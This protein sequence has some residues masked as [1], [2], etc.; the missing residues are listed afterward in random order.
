MSH[1]YRFQEDLQEDVDE[2]RVI[3][4]TEISSSGSLPAHYRFQE[5]NI[6]QKEN[7]NISQ[8]EN[9]DVSNTVHMSLPSDKK[10]CDPGVTDEISSPEPKIRTQQHE[11]D[12]RTK[13]GTQQLLKPEFQHLLSAVIE[14]VID[15]NNP[16]RAEEEVAYRII[17]TIADEHIHQ[18]FQEDVDEEG[19]VDETEISPEDEEK[20]IA[21]KTDLEQSLL[22]AYRSVFSESLNPNKFLDTPPM[23]IILKKFKAYYSAR[24]Y[25]FKP[26]CG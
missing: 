13:K 11:L 17:E 3:G 26:R 1:D 19:V 8:K 22:C 15:E 2:E 14:V 18:I 10:A 21:E 16:T 6:S 23:H 12:I 25:S 9:I 5:D 7:I 20:L 24:L 4:E